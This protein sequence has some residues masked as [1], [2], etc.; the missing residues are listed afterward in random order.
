MKIPER[1]AVVEKTMDV[2]TVNGNF[3]AAE[4][5]VI[6]GD[7]CQWTTHHYPVK[8]PNGERPVMYVAFAGVTGQVFR[9]HQETYIIDG[10]N[11][12]LKLHRRNESDT[13]VALTAWDK[14]LDF[15]KPLD[16]RADCYTAKE[17]HEN[18]LLIVYHLD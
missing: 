10:R 6:Q 9:S 12:Q 3:E 15:D 14:L 13:K 1:F 8:Q 17:G 4:T 5:Y 16:G 11:R 18:Y 7:T 2:N